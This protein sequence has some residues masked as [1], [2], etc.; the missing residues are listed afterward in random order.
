MAASLP[1]KRARKAPEFFIDQ[2]PALMGV[3]TFMEQKAVQGGRK[4]DT[5]EWRAQ[6]RSALDAVFE[7]SFDAFGESHAPLAPGQEPLAQARVRFT[8]IN[9]LPQ[10]D[11][12]ALDRVKAYLTARRDEKQ[13]CATAAARTLGTRRLVLQPDSR[14]AR[15]CMCAA[16]Q[17]A[18]PRAA[19]G[20]ARG[21]R[22]GG[23]RARAAAVVGRPARVVRGDGWAGSTLT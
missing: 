11:R 8:H 19:S 9:G 1:A 21:G 5:D 7:G 12:A 20:G 2:Q 3:R 16:R 6:T 18:L 4:K 22:R 10:L 14:A 23:L 13:V 17:G 15:P